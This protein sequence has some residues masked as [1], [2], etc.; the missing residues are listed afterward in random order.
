MVAER[1]PLHHRGDG[2]E[3]A[4]DP[5]G[6][7]RARAPR[8]RGSASAASCSTPSSRPRRARPSRARVGPPSEVGRQPRQVRRADRRVGEELLHEV[9]VAHRVDRV[10]ERAAECRAGPPSPRG[11]ARASTSRGRRRRA[12][13][14]GRADHSASSR[15]RSRS[16]AHACASRWWPSVTGCAT[17]AWVVPGITVSACSRAGSISA[18][19]SRTRPRRSVG[20]LRAATAGGRSPRGR[21]GERPACSFAPRSPSRSVTAAL[22]RRMHVLVGLVER[23]SRA[24]LVADLRAAPREAAASSASSRPAASQ[25]PTC[26]IEASTSWDASRTS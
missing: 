18:R 12:P 21:C 23:E 9:A 15:S 26:A 5:G 4:G 1:Q 20:P 7:A 25:C 13:S 17:R 14:R 11:R 3:V 2:D 8:C 24:D 19:T 6:L 16:S 10:R 22:D